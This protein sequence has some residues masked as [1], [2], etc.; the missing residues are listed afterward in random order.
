MNR[1]LLLLSVLGCLP[2]FLSAQQLPQN[3][4]YLFDLQQPADSLFRLANPQYLTDFNPS[5]YNNQPHFIA[6]EVLLLTVQYPEDTTQTDIYALDLAKQTK[7][8]MTAT[9][10]SE[11]SPTLIPLY[12]VEDTP[13]F[14]TIRVE[15]DPNN[16]Q[17][18]WS[19]PIDRSNN[20]RPLMPNVKGVGYHCWMNPREVALFIVGENEAPHRL[21]MANVRNENLTNITSNIGRCL[22]KMPR[23][24][25]A[26]LHKLSDRTWLIKKI[27]QNN[28]RPQ[29]ITAS[30][31]GSEDF[32]VLPDGTL[33]AGKGSKLYKFNKSLDVRWV[34][35]ADLSFY[36]INDITRLA[37]NLSGNRLAIVS[38]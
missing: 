1:F 32:V 24:E 23:N 27:G 19:F 21:A 5:G 2:L 16:T 6:D 28:Y 12:N 10:E 20:G 30:L 11:Y 9:Y 13:Q 29:L 3:R 33:L 38:K 34:E 8:R 14:S 35:I 26:F 37:I 22:Q 31:Q 18:L 17:R 36:E 7:T 15:L 4:V 25:L